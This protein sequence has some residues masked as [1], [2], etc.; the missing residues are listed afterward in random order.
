MLSSYGLGIKTGIDLPNEDTG[1]KGKSYSADLLLNLAIGQYDT[2]TPIEL[3]NYINT[4]ADQGQRRK[5]SFVFQRRKR[6]QCLCRI[7]RGF[8]Q[9]SVLVLQ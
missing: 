8:Q 2:Y 5:P 6:K 7:Q 3:L 4:V 1:I 9:T